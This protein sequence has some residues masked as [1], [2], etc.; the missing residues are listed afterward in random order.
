L[1]QEG[2]NIALVGIAELVAPFLFGV[3]VAKSITTGLVNPGVMT[4][5]GITAAVGEG[6]VVF[7][8]MKEYLK[9]M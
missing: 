9:S 7:A 2:I 6:G 8:L 4:L 3:A 5:E 1:I